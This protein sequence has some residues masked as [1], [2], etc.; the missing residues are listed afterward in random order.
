MPFSATSDTRRATSFLSAA[1]RS[2]VLLMEPTGQARTAVVPL[3]LTAAT[4]TLVA[5]T[6]EM[7]SIYDAPLDDAEIRER[8]ALRESR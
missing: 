5:R 4:A 8:Q 3:L 7:R 1:S 2:V 6:I